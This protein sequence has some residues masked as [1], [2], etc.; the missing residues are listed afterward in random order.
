MG[1][2][3]IS[4]KSDRL[5]CCQLKWTVSVVNWWRSRSPVNHTDRRHRSVYD[6]VSMSHCVARVCQRQ[7]RL[8]DSGPLVHYV[9]TRRHPQKYITYCTGDR[10][11]LSHGHRQP[12]QKFGEIW[13]CGFG[14]MWVDR[15]TDT[16]MIIRQT[17]LTDASDLVW[18]PT[19]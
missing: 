9:T 6:T 13:T 1:I 11:G 14:N 12:V 3:H 19:L 17:T 8:V 16:L 7:R 5:R 4:G 2:S 18:P 15:Q 10:G